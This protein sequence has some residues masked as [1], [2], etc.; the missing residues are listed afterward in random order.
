MEFCVIIVYS[1]K[2]LTIF[3]ENSVL[4]ALVFLDP[5]LIKS[6]LLMASNKLVFYR[7]LKY[8]I[9][10]PEN[11]CK[12][13][14]SLENLSLYTKNPLFKLFKLLLLLKTVYINCLWLYI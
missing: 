5:P 8:K 12:V 3:I 13:E 7:L 11:G 14:T 9:I 1:F 10:S 2:P 6:G 4:D